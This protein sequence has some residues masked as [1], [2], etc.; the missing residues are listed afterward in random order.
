MQIEEAVIFGINY[1]IAI[2][3]VVISVA[4]ILFITEKLSVDTVSIIAMALLMDT[5]ILTPEEVFSGF[6][7]PASITVG[8]MFVNSASLFKTGVL[9]G[10]GNLLIKTGRK[11]Y[12]LCLITIMV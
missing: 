4:V 2:V 8:A 7:N 12:L 6:S 9:N 5:G 11:S 10:L 1:E 3:L